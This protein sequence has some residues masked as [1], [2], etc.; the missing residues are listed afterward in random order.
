MKT[1]KNIILSCSV[2]LFLT[3][4]DQGF[5]ELNKSPY[6]LND[7]DPQLLLANSQR[8]TPSVNWEGESTIAQHFLNAYNLGATSGFNFNED[9]DNFNGSRWGIF[10]G[11]S[12]SL[13]QGIADIG[14]DPDKQNL[15]NVMRIWKAYNFMQLVDTYADVPYSEAGKAY[16]DGI[17]YPVY[18]DD[19]L[20]YEGLYDE[21]KSATAALSTSSGGTF[22]ADLFYG[23]DITKWRKL[24]YSLLLRLGMRY[25]K[26]NT[27]RAQAIVSEAVAGGVMQTADDDAYYI[28]SVQFPA[29]GSGIANNNPYFYYM[30]EPLVDH[31]KATN[32]PR[33]KYM[34]AK[35]ED[36][37]VVLGD[38]AEWSTD[39]DDQFGFPVGYDNNTIQ[40]KQDYRGTQGQGFN[41]SQPNY[42]VMNNVLAP[43]YFI[44]AS[45][46]KLLM[47]EAVVRGWITGNAAQLYED[48]IRESMAQWSNYPNTPS[49]AV[50]EAEIIAYL[51][52]SGVAYNATNALNLINTQYW[53][54]NV[55]NGAEAWANFRRTGF[56][57]LS[58]NLYNN[59]LNGG[60]VRRMAY[61]NVEASDNPDNYAAAASA[62][63]GDNLTSR[64]FWD[65]Q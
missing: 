48:G 29:P 56:P 44:T 24:G 57:A 39:L 59:N 33:S 47:A 42:N 14:D 20:V 12:K 54:S 30:A 26:V 9:N 25:S 35:Y 43:V 13:I 23:G 65:V 37:N 64:V 22:T 4:C 53:V 28:N 27:N 3:G 61:P 40:S 58:P 5:E 52:E 46:T 51:A 31:L 49:P 18:D 6:Q 32:D 10:T 7:L 21:I 34:V 63:G 16:L 62:I 55:H 15:K 38:D 17:Y 19:A 8:Q 1:I 36:P 60:F 41:Y 50:T 45:Q 11:A 2:V